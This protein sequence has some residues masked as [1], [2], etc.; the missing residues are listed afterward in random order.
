M[1]EIVRCE[2]DR[3]HKFK[4]KVKFKVELKIELKI[5]T[6]KFCRP[7]LARC[8]WQKFDLLQSFW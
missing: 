3:T 2:A 4:L 1:Q 7:Q 5:A 8:K 6:S